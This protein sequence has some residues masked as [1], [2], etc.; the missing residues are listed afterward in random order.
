MI[1]DSLLWDYPSPIQTNKIKMK[2]FYDKH[3]FNETISV[4]GT[5]S[6]QMS[7]FV[8]RHSNKNIIEIPFNYNYK[9]P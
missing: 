3:F 2:I 9:S 5:K 1:F 4:H 8:R 7:V 6:N